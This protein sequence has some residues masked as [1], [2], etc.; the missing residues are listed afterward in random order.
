MTSSRIEEQYQHI[1]SNEEQI[2]QV[3][4]FR[5]RFV[6]PEGKNNI[7]NEYIEFQE[8]IVD[9]ENREDNQYLE[10][11]NDVEQIFDDTEEYE[12]ED[13]LVVPVGEPDLFSVTVNVPEV[14]LIASPLKPFNPRLPTRSTDG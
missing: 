2:R 3:H 12:G 5:E 7:Q 11:L 9:R 13:T 6:E 14:T 10:I 8:N 4:I 1:C